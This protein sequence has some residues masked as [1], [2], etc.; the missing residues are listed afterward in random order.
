VQWL[1][2]QL[3]QARGQVADTSQ[4]P[5]FDD[6]LERQVKQFQLDRGLVPDGR[7][8]LQTLMRLAGVGDRSA[9][10]LLPRQGGR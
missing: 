5:L 2:G 9:P 4:A 3:A 10:E 6:A 8:G 7:V 1:I